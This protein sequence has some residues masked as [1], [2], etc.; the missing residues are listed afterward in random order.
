MP[1][2]TPSRARILGQVASGV[3]TERG[4]GRIGMG[5]RARVIR[6][7]SDILMFCLHS[8]E[9]GG[10]GGGGGARRDLEERKGEQFG[11]AVVRLIIVGRKKRKQRCLQFFAPSLR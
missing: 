1:G 11:I 2:S 7:R 5:A 4:D 9:N 10:G 6:Y 8:A 3:V